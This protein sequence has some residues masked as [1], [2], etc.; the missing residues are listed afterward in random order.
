MIRIGSSVPKSDSE[1]PYTHQAAVGNTSGQ[2]PPQGLP[3]NTT[4][5][6]SIQEV[7]PDYNVQGR[8]ADTLF[9][10]LPP[11]R[12]NAL[13]PGAPAYNNP[14]EPLY[15]WEDGT[16]SLVDCAYLPEASQ[17]H[18]HPK[19][20]YLYK[21]V[22]V[23]V[24]TRD[25]HFFLSVPFDARRANVCTSDPPRW[26][27]IGLDYDSFRWDNRM[28]YSCVGCPGDSRTLATASVTPYV[29]DLLPLPYIPENNGSYPTS[30][31]A[32]LAGSLPL[33]LALIAL[34]CPPESL[35]EVLT[36]SVRLGTWKPH[37]FQHGR[38]L[39]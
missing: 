25:S 39:W 37:K 18:S 20:P 32:G 11:D 6:F 22:T 27:E 8:R 9:R 12:W 35:Q 14:P 38:K 2:A 34:S 31:D 16:M 24:P 36:N 4:F 30:Q 26:L 29:K 23:F 21:A 10:W 1:A 28:V 33:L 3:P 5:L 13:T 19:C 15:R 7:R 17:L